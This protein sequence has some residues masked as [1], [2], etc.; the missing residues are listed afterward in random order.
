ML[1]ATMMGALATTSASSIASA[2]TSGIYL[3]CS[4]YLTSRTK[5][6]PMKTP[7]F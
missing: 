7:K 2:V 5:K 3:G 1:F 6:N 4:L